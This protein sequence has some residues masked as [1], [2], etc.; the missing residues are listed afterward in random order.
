[1][2]R[3]TL[4]LSALAG[5]AAEARPQDSTAG[6]RAKVMAA[7]RGFA[8]TMARRDHAAFA[9]FLSEEAVFFTNREDQPLRGKKAVAEGWKRFFEG[10]DAAFSWEPTAVEALD[11]GTLA[12]STGPVKDTKGEIIGRFNSIWRLESGQWRVVF[13]KG[14]QVCKA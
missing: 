9:T 7:E 5:F 10:P 3:R 8:A 14:C 1:M 11:S 13:D 6:A 4:M 12:L 2:K